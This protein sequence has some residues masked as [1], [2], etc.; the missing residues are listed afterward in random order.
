MENAVVVQPWRIVR[1]HDI[2]MDHIHWKWWI[3]RARVI[4]K[5]H[6]QEN[7]YGDLQIRLILIDEL[8][9]KME[10][11]VYR[12]QAEHFN[13]LL[14]C[15]SV[16]DFYNVGFDPTE[17]IVHLRFKIR[18]QFCMILNNVTTTRT[19]H[20]VIG[21]VVH[22]GDIEF[23]SLYLRQ[24]PTRIIALVNPRLQII[25]VR[26][27]DQQLT[28]NLTRW[29]SART[30]FDC[31]VATLTRVDRRADELSTTY[32]SD[33]IFNPD[34]ASAN[35]FNV[36]RQ[37]L[38]VSP[39]NVQEQERIFH[40]FVILLL[41]VILCKN[42]YIKFSSVEFDE[43]KMEHVFRTCWKQNKFGAQYI[44]FILKD[45]TD[46]RM[47]ALAYDQQADRFNGTIQSGLVYNFTN[48]GFQP[49]D[50]PTY[51][52]LTM[53]AKFCMI[54]TPKTALRKP[55]FVDF[56]AIFTDAIS[57]DMFIDVVGVLIYVGEIH[58]HQ[59]YGQSLPT[60]DIALVNRRV[61]ASTCIIV[62]LHVCYM[63]Q[64][65]RYSNRYPCLISCGTQVNQD[66]I[67]ADMI[68]TPPSKK[69]KN[70]E[71]EEHGVSKVS[72]PNIDVPSNLIRSMF[73]QTYKYL[74]QDYELTNEDVMAIFLIEDSAEN[75]TLVDMG[76][77]YNKKRHLT[78]LLSGDKFLND[79]VISAYI[80][81]LSEQANNDK[82]VKYEN[83]FLSDM[84]KAAGV[85]GVN[86][87][88]DNFI[89]KIVKN[90]LHH[91]LIFIPINMKDNHWYLAV[92]NIE[93][94][95]I[96]VLDSMCMTFN[97]ADLANTLQRLQYHLNII[98]RQQDLPSHKWG[99]LNVIKWPI[100]EQLKE[101]I[102][103]DSSSCGLFMLKLMEN[104]TGESLSRSITQEDITLFRSKLASVLLRWKTNKAVMTTG[105][106]IED[107]KDSDDDVV[108]L[109]SKMSKQ[110]LISGL[111]HYI[112]QINCAEAMEK[113]WVQSSRPHY[114]SLS[115]KQLQTILKK[116]EP[117]ESDCFN[118]AIRKFMY[119]KI[120]MIHKTKQAISNHCLDLQFWS[121]T[122]FGKVPVHHDNI[123]LAETVGSWSEI[124]YKLSQCKAILIPVRHAR[125]FIVLV[126]DQE[127]QTLYVLD[128]NPLMPEYKNNP[129]MRYTRK[130]ITICDHFNKAMRKACPGS[131][132]N[133]DINLW[134]QV[135][136]NNPVYSR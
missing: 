120:E 119:E 123:N 28:R 50:V 76:H 34:S 108:I 99:D 92:V 35:E 51:A 43:I 100:I 73:G 46:T 79:D 56:S 11:I 115:L 87:D 98:G 113:I 124:H 121:A 60:R 3:V 20:D 13:Q 90:Y 41:F 112:Q 63:S 19:P 69:A 23:R 37:A 22:V 125:S 30:H 91:E 52:N 81:C 55:R 86:E 21:L 27:W 122:G 89:T 135:I 72:M 88:E 7:Y 133:E 107:T 80:H 95:Q 127:S 78:C 85:N 9:T 130:L 14:R 104:W 83:P 15:G 131:R 44:R 117:L 36:L 136:V 32:E 57:D 105:E 65:I 68:T 58:H 16:Y 47:E 42:F 24:T 66:A 48:V 40:M 17:M 54:L 12:R 132:W 106:Q 18:S 118:M 94:K 39:S 110:E 38:A 126:V 33:I 49:T 70:S 4:K 96:Q 116:D 5:G 64:E 84:L 103:E 97:R 111:L 53:Q 101:R 82:K 25:F 10:A 134:R 29:R 59:L 8:G 6:L 45:T 71:S 62:L 26:V 93:K 1:F 128:P 75:C 114:I 67:H 102:Q 61:V 109:V 77:F 31:F 129:N 2:Q 74:P